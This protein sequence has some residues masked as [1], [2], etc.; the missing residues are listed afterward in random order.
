MSITR[1]F[2]YLCSAIFRFK[3]RGGRTE[4]RKAVVHK[5]AF[6]CT[7]GPGKV[8]FLNKKWG[9][10]TRIC[11]FMYYR[12]RIEEPDDNERTSDSRKTYG[13][14]LYA[15]RPSAVGPVSGCAQ[16]EDP[17]ERQYGY[18]PGGGRRHRGF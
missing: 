6:S 13:K 1:L 8:V 7:T 16:G 15:F 14:P 18:Q 4:V 2:F 17:S 3:E 12:L 11:I 5:S 9:G 10:G